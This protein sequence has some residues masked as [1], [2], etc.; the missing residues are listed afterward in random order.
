MSLVPISTAYAAICALIILALAFRVTVFRRGRRV[1]YG[2]DE[3]KAMRGAMRAH[4][5]AVEYLPIA[6]I[7][8][9]LFELNGGSGKLTHLLG[10][11]LVVARVFHAWGLSKSLG[12]SFGRFYGTIATWLVILVGAAL[13]LLIVIPAFR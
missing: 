1:G 3:S 5:N 13:N 10:A 4:A 7:L 6:L 8:I 2:D 9:I 12:R 11:T